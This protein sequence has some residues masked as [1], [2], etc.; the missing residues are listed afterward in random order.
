MFCS[1]AG[2]DNL[3]TTL[4]VHGRYGDNYNG[5]GHHH[6]HHH[7]HHHRHQGQQSPCARQAT[8]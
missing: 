7:H 3:T 4:Y 1:L 2:S 6:H 5:D 8:A